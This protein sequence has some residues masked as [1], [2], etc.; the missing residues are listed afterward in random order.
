VAFLLICALEGCEPGELLE[1]Y[2]D[3]V[4]LGTVADVVPLLGENRAFIRA[5]LERI[6]GDA[7][8]LGLA[9]LRRV[10]RADKRQLSATGVAFT[11]APRINAAGRMEHASLALELLLTEDAEKAERLAQRLELLNEERQ[12]AEQEILEQV[13]AWLAA[14]PGR[15]YDRVLVFAG[16]GWHEGVVGIVASRLAE[17]YGRPC[18]LLSIT[19]GIAKGSGRSLPG[20]SLFDAIHHCAALMIKYGGHE[21]AAGF[22]LA[23]ADVEQLRAQ[24]NAYAAQG[25]MPFPRQQL[26]ARLHAARLA[27][28]LADEIALLEPFGAGNPQPVFLLRQMTLKAATPVS[29]GKHLRLALE[30]EGAALTAM[31]FHTRREEFTFSPGDVLDLAVNIENNEYN[32]KREITLILKNAKHSAIPN[33]ALLQAQRLVEAALRGE[34][35]PAEVAAGC[36]PRRETAA[37]VFRALEQQRER[38]IAPEALFLALGTAFLQKAKAPDFARVWLAAEVLRELGIVV[39]DAAGRMAL[40]QPAV[41]ARLEDAALLQRLTAR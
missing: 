25:E 11:L 29:N 23:A 24:I 33:E 39:A 6:N 21:L 15:E 28:E 16:E 40:A 26:D 5:G 30:G 32:G 31:A 35:L 14:H 27:P 4:A 18:L 20:F 19:D 38:P 17:R 34:A 37:R 1:E 36:T 3:L 2:G 13:L 7:P 41:K 12:Q 9:A 10:A 22:S 8:R